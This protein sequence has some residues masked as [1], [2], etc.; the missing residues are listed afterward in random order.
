MLWMDAQGSQEHTAG[1]V[2][3]FVSLTL[4]THLPK[5]LDP[6][7]CEPPLR[8]LGICE[9]LALEVGGWREAE[10]AGTTD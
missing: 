1:S 4:M 6:M 7:C 9:A 8:P 2:H 5:A 3:L 10:M